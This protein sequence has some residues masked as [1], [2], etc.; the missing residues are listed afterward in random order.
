MNIL[1][2]DTAMASCGVAFM[3][4]GAIVAERSL[5]Q[6]R[7]HAET[8]MPLLEEFRHETGFAYRDLAAIAVTIGPGT[9]AGIRVGLAA[10]RAIALPT[11]A[12]IVGLTSLE[13]LAAEA[14]ER[15]SPVTTGAVA[16]I[17]DA[18]NGKVYLQVVGVDQ[19]TRI[20]AR[21]VAI[22]EAA[23]LIDGVAGVLCGDGAPLVATHLAAPR[24]IVTRASGDALQ[25]SPRLL[26]L[27]AADAIARRGLSAFRRP[28][29]PLYLRS[30]DAKLPTERR[31]PP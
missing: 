31:R 7:G 13:V 22:D 5:L 23:R 6:S 9:F 10:A 4:A 20:E 1:A 28:P 19:L 11:A 21:L 29:R 27:L 3:R 8:L 15:T 12:A 16:A 17:T 14:M 18:R 2:L 24:V 30:P 26:A 25:P